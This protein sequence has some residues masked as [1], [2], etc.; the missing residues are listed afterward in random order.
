MLDV[1]EQDF[2]HLKRD[3]S[4]LVEFPVFPSKLIELIELCLNC[5]SSNNHSNVVAG[6]GSSGGEHY[7]SNSSEYNSST[8]TA[9]L[10]ISSGLLAI[11]ESNKFK[12]LT[13]ISLQLRPGNDAAVK[14]YLSSRLAFITSVANRK[15]NELALAL[16]ELNIE[17][18]HRNQVSAELSELKALRDTDVQI[19]R[20]RHSEEVTRLRMEQLITLENERAKGD[21][22]V[23]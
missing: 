15:K 20:S 10:E 19:V 9:N 1:G 6:S 22:Q 5:S 16:S 21:T 4:L 3:Q 23:R 14:G 17:R 7:T 11:V 12:Q 13:H 18:Q 2:H 8:F